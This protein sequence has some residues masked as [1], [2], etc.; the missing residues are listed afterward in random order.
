MKALHALVLI[1]LVTSAPAALSAQAVQQGPP[2]RPMITTYMPQVDNLDRAEAFYHGLLGLESIQGDPRARLGYYPGNAFLND[3]YGV[4]GNIKNFYLR[5][6]L[7]ELT[8]EP[9]QWSEAKG[10]P[11]FPRLQDPGASRLVLTVNNIDALAK[12]LT[13][14]GAKVVTTGGKPV[15]VRDGDSEFRVLVV[16]DFNGFFVDLVQPGSLPAAAPGAAPPPYFITGASIALTVDDIEKA[17]T[18]YR[19]VLGL[20]VHVDPAFAAEAQRLKAFGMR[21]AQYRE[22]RVV[23]PD[24]TPQIRLIEFKGIDRKPI[25]PLVPEPNATVIRI[26]IRDDMNTAVAKVKA[27]GAKIMNLAGGPFTN[28]A[29]QW[30]MVAGPGGVYHQ[31]VAPVPGGTR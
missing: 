17:A 26:N 3:M 18:F 6:P 20:E 15:S 27:S 30:L 22:A 21:R 5:V 10:K 19:D 9:I 11:L 7:T 14:G 13:A 28:G 25:T 12:Y 23:W 31:L 24:K 16:K 4:G 8:V 29:T 2:P 1:G